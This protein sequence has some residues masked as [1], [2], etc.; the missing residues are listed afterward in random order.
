MNDR[1]IVNTI[2]LFCLFL[3]FIQIEIHSTYSV[4]NAWLGL[5]NIV[6]VKCIYIVIHID[7]LLFFIIVYVIVQLISQC[8]YPFYFNGHQGNFH[9]S[10]INYFSTKKIKQVLALSLCCSTLQRG[11]KGVVDIECLFIMLH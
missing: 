5:L 4:H 3:K 8:I 6:S 7:D 10:L 2:G 1:P 11:G 9:Y